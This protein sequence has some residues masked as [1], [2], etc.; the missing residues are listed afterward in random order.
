M[1]EMKPRPNLSSGPP[2]S[3]TI[4]SSIPQLGAS[5]GVDWGSA[6]GSSPSITSVPKPFP[7]PTLEEQLEYVLKDLIWLEGYIVA[8][9]GE[10]HTKAL[11]KIEGLRRIRKEILASILKPTL[12]EGK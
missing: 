2:I 12:T 5:W 9:G 7:I 11:R 1:A 8:L 3:Q 4:P 6:Q 10:N